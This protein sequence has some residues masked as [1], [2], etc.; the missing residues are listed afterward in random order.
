MTDTDDQREQASPLRLQTRSTEKLE[1]LAPEKVRQLER[2]LR[3]SEERYR[4]LV[5]NI[6]DCIWEVDSQ[7]RFTYLSPTFKDLLGYYPAEF[8]G[9]SPIDLVQEDEAHQVGKNFLAVVAARQPFSFMEHQNRHR[10]GRL[11]TVEV[12]GIPLFSPEGEYLGM[13]GITRDISKRKA[14]EEA[15]GEREERYRLLVDNL[16]NAVV[17]QLI[18]TPDGG[19]RFTYVSRAV[20]R[21]NETTVEEVLADAGVI[22]GQLLPEYRAL[23][24]EREEEALK[25]LSV[26]HVEVQSRLP[27]GRI[28]WFEYTSTPRR[29]KDG[30]LVWDG[31]QVDITDR[32]RAESDLRRANKRLDLAQSA[33]GAGVWDWDIASGRIEWSPELF[34]LFGLD[35]EKEPAGFETWRGVLH[36]DDLQAASERIEKAVREGSILDSEYRVRLRDGTIRWINAR[37]RTICDPGGQ[38]LSMLGICIDITK[39]KRAETAL[40]E[41]LAEKEVLLR[42]VHHRVKNNMASIVGLL[43]LQTEWITDELAL[44]SLKDLADRIQSMAL[45]HE[46]LYRSE[47]LA[48]IDF[49]GY[50]D[51]LVA[52]L[53]TSY[54][55]QSHIRCRVEATG[56]EVKLDTAI[57]IGLVVNELVTN[58]M[59]HA[60]PMGKQRP[61]TEG[62]NILITVQKDEDTT[63]L[64]VADNGV[65]LPPDLDWRS[66]PSLG[67][68]LVR[69]L[70]EHQLG[71][72]IQLDQAEGTRF[73]LRF[74]DR[75]KQLRGR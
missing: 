39:R 42:E 13:R 14:T 16:Q 43:D 27:S 33:A 74:N 1:A 9:R 28:R 63:T 68:R 56:A 67:L 21:L 54:G 30:Q 35:P 2:Q 34:H 37:G 55:V 15:L 36:P 71:G 45:V 53:L 40:Q 25:N 4:S 73:I 20:E 57:P 26:L 3:T 65:G 11:V 47:N 50:L 38:P 31:V 59:K 32:K 41:S 6:S 24:R 23:V 60:F 48:R 49:Q 22:Y 7:G 8:L 17:Y 12:R 58:A 64:T 70:G 75:R 69:M 61:G 19:T 46:R 51:D 18:P 44:A 29:R 66:C 52:H 10:D 72:Q 62:C 5:E